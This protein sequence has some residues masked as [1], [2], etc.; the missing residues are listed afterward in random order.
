MRRRHLNSTTI[1]YISQTCHTKEDMEIWET[2]AHSRAIS[3]IKNNFVS[4]KLNVDISSY[5]KM[6]VGLS[7]VEGA[8]HTYGY[9]V[10][11]K[12]KYSY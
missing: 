4:W 12:N 9:M 1:F 5:R 11:I 2:R 7:N 6:K 10:D 8:A 3:V